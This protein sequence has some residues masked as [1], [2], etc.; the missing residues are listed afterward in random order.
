MYRK[1]EIKGAS[2]IYGRGGGGGFK[3]GICF[4]TDQGGTKNFFGLWPRGT[5]EKNVIP[6]EGAA[7]FASHMIIFSPKG[8]VLGG[9]SPSCVSSQ[10][11]ML[12]G[13][14]LISKAPEGDLVKF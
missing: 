4:T 6:S 8:H 9:F 14:R 12:R 2:I 11:I 1:N 5:Q 13:P 7:F 3:G 10:I